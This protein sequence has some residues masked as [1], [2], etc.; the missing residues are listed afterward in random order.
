[1]KTSSRFL[2][3]AALLLTASFSHAALIAHYDFGDGNI[4]TGLSATHTYKI[5][6]DY[7]VT[8]VVTD[9]A[10][11]F[12]RGLQPKKT[13]IEQANDSKSRVTARPW[14]FKSRGTYRCHST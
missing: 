1:M 5:P 2:I 14:H 6:G 3:V 7:N 10:G 9:S 13:K 8:F 12:F 11:N 4:G